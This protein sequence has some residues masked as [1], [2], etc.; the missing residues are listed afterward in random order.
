M[1]E[2]G[3][4]VA[5]VGTEHRCRQ[6]HH[7]RGGHEPDRQRQ[8]PLGGAGDRDDAQGQRTE[9]ERRA[10]VRLQQHQPHGDGGHR[11]REGE[12]A[13]G[14]LGAPVQPLAQEAHGLLEQE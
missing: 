3:Q 6:R 4:P 5:L 13:H 11:G 7:D 9:D 1:A 2:R 10:Q 8:P 12:V 14:R